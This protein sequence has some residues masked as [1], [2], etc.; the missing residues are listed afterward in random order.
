MKSRVALVCVVTFGGAEESDPSVDGRAPAD[1]WFPESWSR[2]EVNLNVRCVVVRCR[3]SR[4][5]PDDG[6]P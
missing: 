6:V 5:R 4:R 2:V 3:P 1:R